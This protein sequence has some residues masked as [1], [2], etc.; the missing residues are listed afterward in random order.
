MDDKQLSNRYLP[1]HEF[2]EAIEAPMEK[3]LIK[4]VMWFVVGSVFLVLLWSVFADIEEIAKAKGQVVPLGHKQVIQSQSGG[5]LASVLVTE[6]DLVSKGDVIASFVSVD[7]QAVE[8][9][10]LGQQAN[11]QLRIE[12]YNAFIEGRPADFS[13]YE[14]T[15]PAL[16]EQHQKS[17][18]R[19][20]K[21]REAIM[22]LSESE[23]AKSNAELSSIDL[24]IPPLQDQINSSRESLRLMNSPR[25]VQAVSKLT[26]SETQQKLDAYL[27]E[28]KSL[29]GRRTVL[30][31]NIDNQRRQFEQREATL[32]K[33]VGEKRADAHSELIGVTARLKSS[34]LQIQQDTVMSPVDGIIQSIPNTSSGSVIQPGGT[35]A[36]VVPTTPTAILEAKLSPRDIGFVTVGQPA[37][38]KIDAFDYSRYGAID[39]VVERISPTTDADEKGG[40]YYKVRIAIEKPYFGAEPGK[41]NLLPG[42]TGEADIVTGEKTIFQYLWKPVFTNMREAFGE[43]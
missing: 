30:E 24:E 38:I 31:R 6:G 27:R 12:R 18:A 25:G 42:M 23:I 41:L 40:V 8:E 34:D 14:L 3:R 1:E 11:L 37:K 20:N 2:T 28:L 35:V 9:E 13:S 7:S 32:F 4:Q 33:E 39:G 17:L 29:E 15:Y 21:E 36:V 10:L 26:I 16:V 43:R 19:M 22:Q 5:T